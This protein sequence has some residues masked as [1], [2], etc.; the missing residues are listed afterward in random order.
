[1]KI[2]HILLSIFTYSALVGSSV[3]VAQ[4]SVVDQLLGQEQ[5]TVAD[6]ERSVRGYWHPSW[7][8]DL[9]ADVGVVREGVNLGGARF[10]PHSI[11]FESLPYDLAIVRVKG[12]GS[13]QIS[14]IV[15]PTCPHCKRLEDELE[16]LDNVTI[17]TFVAAIL[18][19]SSDVVDQIQCAT[20]HKQRALAYDYYSKHNSHLYSKKTCSTNISSKI[21]TSIGGYK[22]LDTATPSVVFPSNIFVSSFLTK[23]ELESFLDL[24]EVEEG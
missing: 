10:K 18:G 15:D 4:Q 24:G 6:S 23:D 16:Q 12:D 1:M 11:D 2:K 5:A 8:P 7:E 3:T 20:S 9:N 22:T 19:G 14:I 13:R 21:L 17:Y